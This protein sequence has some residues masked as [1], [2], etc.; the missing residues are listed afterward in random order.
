MTGP[1]REHFSR[2]IEDG[3]ALESGSHAELIGRRGTYQ[4]FFASQFGEGA[5]GVT[6]WPS[7]AGRR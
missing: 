7:A 3:R 1:V 2:F 5:E 6:R 4:K